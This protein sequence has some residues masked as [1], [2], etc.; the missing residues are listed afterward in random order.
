MVINKDKFLPFSFKTKLPKFKI[1]IWIY[2]R[3]P[4]KPFAKQM[5]IIAAK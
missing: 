1:L 2:L 5:L 4:Y 3:L